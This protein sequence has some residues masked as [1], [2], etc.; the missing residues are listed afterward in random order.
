MRRPRSLSTSSPSCRTRAS[1]SRL[2]DRAASR[3]WPNFS[4]WRR[5]REIG[6]GGAILGLRQLLLARGQGVPKPR[7]L[8]L[9]VRTKVC[10]RAFVLLLLR[11]LHA[12]LGVLHAVA[13]ATHHGAVALSHKNRHRPDPSRELLDQRVK[14]HRGHG[15]VAA[16]R[17]SLQ[18]HQR[19]PQIPQMRRQALLALRDPILHRIQRGAQGRQLRPRAHRPARASARPCGAP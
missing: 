6:R 12:R 15:L 17:V 8:A 5:A 11:L 14:R 1:S 19:R 16:L 4:A 2:A 7:V 18:L 9:Q 3:S 13:N 10:Q